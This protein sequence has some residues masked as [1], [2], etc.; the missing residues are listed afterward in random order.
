[1]TPMQTALW[2]VTW[3][4]KRPKMLKRG[5]CMGAQTATAASG[6]GMGAT[7]ADTTATTPRRALTVLGAMRVTRGAAHTATRQSLSSG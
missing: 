5:R 2:T 3:M 4:E 1:M 7:T 6:A